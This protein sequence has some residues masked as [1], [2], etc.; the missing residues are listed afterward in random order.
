MELAYSAT[1][2]AASGTPSWWVMTAPVPFSS[3]A[4]RFANKRSK[5]ICADL[6]VTPAG[7][8][9]DQKCSKPNQFIFTPL[10][11]H[12]LVTRTTIL[13]HKKN[14]SGL[15]P[16]PWHFGTGIYISQSTEWSLLRP[17]SSAVRELLELE[18]AHWLPRLTATETHLCHW[19]VWFLLESVCIFSLHAIS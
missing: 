6:C 8:P 17:H 10:F 16:Y 7:E 11:Q 9:L 14:Y 18:V 4:F 15:L 19:G 1:T 5:K 13:G 3:S 2:T 12:I